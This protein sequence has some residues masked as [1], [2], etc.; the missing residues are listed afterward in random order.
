MAGRAGILFVCLV[1]NRIGSLVLP[2]T[3]EQARFRGSGLRQSES[4]A[5]VVVFE[6]AR[7]TINFRRARADLFCDRPPGGRGGCDFFD[8]RAGFGE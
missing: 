5:E 2:A 4:A 6:G 3:F 7:H 1:V 8:D